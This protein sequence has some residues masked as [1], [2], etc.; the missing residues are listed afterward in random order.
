MGLMEQVEFWELLFTPAKGGV[1]AGRGQTY[2]E[3]LD[4]RFTFYFWRNMN[5]KEHMKPKLSVCIKI[6]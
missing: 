5:N 2:Q 6:Y 1:E 4:M 3:H